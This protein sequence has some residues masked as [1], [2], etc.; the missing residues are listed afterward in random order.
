MHALF[1]FFCHLCCYVNSK[2]FQYSLDTTNETLTSTHSTME[3]PTC[4]QPETEEVQSDDE[5]SSLAETLP[6]TI[7]S[8]EDLEVEAINSYVPPDGTNGGSTKE[9]SSTVVK[10]RIQELADYLNQ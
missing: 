2:S 8:I 10:E 5:N 1:K 4:T 7:D 6:F 3:E 9:L